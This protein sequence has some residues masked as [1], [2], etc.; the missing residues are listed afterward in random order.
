[1]QT[2]WIHKRFS[3][4][5][6]KISER[7]TIFFFLKKKC[8]PSTFFQ[9]KNYILRLSISIASVQLFGQTKRQ[10]GKKMRRKKERRTACILVL[11]FILRKVR[12]TTPNMYPSHPTYL[13][14]F[15][16]MVTKHCRFSTQRFLCSYPVTNRPK[17]LFPF[18]QW[19]LFLIENTW[20]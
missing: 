18:V 8:Q 6:R 13:F 10:R 19:H 12:H 16:V 3:T 17:I 20:N 7:L 15:W 11:Y 1:M 9:K 4:W 5:K 2:K 14:T